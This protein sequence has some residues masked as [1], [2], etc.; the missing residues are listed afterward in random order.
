[1]A[2]KERSD[3][4]GSIYQRHTP[5]CPRTGRCPCRWQGAL[6]TDWRDDKPVRKKVSGTSRAAVAAKLRTLRQQVEAGQM[7]TGR[8]MTVGEWLT[9]WLDQIAA[10]EVRHNTLRGYRTYVTRYLIPLLGSKRL[11]RLTPE[12]IA[13]AYAHLMTTGCPGDP[14]PTPLSTTSVLQAHRILSRALRI[15]H[16]RGHVGRNVAKLVTAPR[17]AETDIHPLTKAEAERVLEAAKG[18]RNSARWT[19][20]LALGLRQGEALGLRWEHVDLEAGVIAVR[21]ALSRK[22]G[23]GL[24]LGPVKSKAGRRTI[25]LPPKM[26]AAMRAHRTAQN[27]ER[28]TAGSRW[29]DGGFVFT[30]VDGRPIDPRADWGEWKSLLAEAG[31]RDARLHDARHTAAT[32]MLAMDVH[33]RTAMEILG[34]S[35]LT[36]TTNYAHVL[37]EMHEDAAEKMGA[38]WG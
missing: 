22:A 18:R 32:M 33:P 17:K 36:Q 11:D 14:N 8:T 4:E 29:H 6:V 25:K 34:H 13:D 16:E 20:A 30:R 3:G 10:R 21:K 27:A 5:D 12:H 37:D 19:V 9:Y 23:E 35:H 1:M 26:A 24:V 2:S 7:P 28:L 15:A 38:F 31:V